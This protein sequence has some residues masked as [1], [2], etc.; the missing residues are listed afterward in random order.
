MT[1]S[2]MHLV[3]RR[4]TEGPTAWHSYDGDLWPKEA[5]C[6]PAYVVRQHTS[7]QLMPREGTLDAKARAGRR[8]VPLQ[9]LASCCHVMGGYDGIK[10][11]RFGPLRSGLKH[12]PAK[13]DGELL[14]IF[15][16]ASKNR[17]PI[18]NGSKTAR[19]RDVLQS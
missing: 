10:L 5:A 13:Q 3:F 15:S 11:N 7:Q 1:G 4:P 9:A 14:R 18:T 17:H 12:Y 16:S 19:G 6:S 8:Y 2:P